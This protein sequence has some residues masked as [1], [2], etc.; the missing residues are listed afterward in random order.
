M[1]VIFCAVFLCSAVA[2]C[3][4]QPNAFL[5]ALLDGA[6]SS[7]KTALT[8]FCVYAVWM[9]LS[10]VAED[11]G[12]N[13]KAAKMLRPFCRK[14]FRTDNAA[15]AQ[16]ISMNLSCN[17][18]GLGGAATPFAVKAIEE[19]E[20]D[21]NVFAQNLL[22]IVNATSIQLI[23]TTVIAL[24]TAADSVT[25]NDIVLPSLLATAVS[26]GLAAGLYFTFDFLRR[27]KDAR[28]SG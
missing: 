10:A 17:L 1:N 6:F 13:A 21:G 9:G 25:P 5:S 12:V 3:I 15:A 14:F 20:K 27:K 22:F 19:L 2:I 4:F 16:D 23:P 18:L 24:R 11:A 28:K 7:A 8:L 26:T